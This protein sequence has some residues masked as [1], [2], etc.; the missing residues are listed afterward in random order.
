MHLWGPGGACLSEIEPEREQERGARERGREREREREEG[1]A[2]L[3]HITTTD[4]KKPSANPLVHHLSWHACAMNVETRTQQNIASVPQA[5]HKGSHDAYSAN[6]PRTVHVAVQRWPTSRRIGGQRS[7]EPNH[8]MKGGGRERGRRRA[9]RGDDRGESR[10]LRSFF[11]NTTFLLFSPFFSGVP[12][13]VWSMQHLVGVPQ[14]DAAPRK[15][16]APPVAC[17]LRRRLLLWTAGAQRA[18]PRSCQRLTVACSCTAAARRVASSVGSARAAA[19]S[20]S[21]T[22]STGR[23]LAACGRTRTP[24]ATATCVA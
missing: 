20:L 9:P 10:L 1:I 8:R 19:P 17:P 13:H 6:L 4:V 16:V 21:R 22:Q 7:N 12:V 3:C 11:Y 24:S 15:M 2:T 14:S 5:Y 23:V 18:P